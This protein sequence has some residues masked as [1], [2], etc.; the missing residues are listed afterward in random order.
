VRSSTCLFVLAEHLFTRYYALG[1]NGSVAALMGSWR[2]IAGTI[3]APLSAKF[4]MPIFFPEIGY[5]ALSETFVTPWQANGTLSPL[6][7]S[8]CYLALYQALSHESWFL[9]PMWW[10]FT[11]AP[12]DGG[13]MQPGFSFHNKPAA[14]IIS[15]QGAFK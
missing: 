6:T 9:G 10:A 7:Q 2:H 14:A 5:E 1:K 8:D 4:G 12:E 11:D 3:L 15:W 13:A